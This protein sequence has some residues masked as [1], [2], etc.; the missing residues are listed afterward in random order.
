MAEKKLNELP[1]DL[2]RL[3]SKAV[4]AAQR[5]NFDYAT[6]LLCQL[7]KTEPAMFDAR[8]ALRAP[9]LRGRRARARAFSKK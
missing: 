8:K 5:E 4:E 9:R 1:P 2:R 3:Y 6:T 7:L